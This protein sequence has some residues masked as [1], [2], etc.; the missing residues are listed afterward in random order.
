MVDGYFGY[1]NE[2][3]VE[4]EDDGGYQFPK[5]SNRGIEDFYLE[6]EQDRELAKVN[7]Q[8]LSHLFN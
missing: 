5:P 4:I 7:S 6:L 8:E 1:G 3:E 2:D